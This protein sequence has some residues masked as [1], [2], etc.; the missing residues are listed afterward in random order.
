M[1]LKSKIALSIILSIAV[2]VFQST[3]AMAASQTLTVGV[4]GPF[5]GP[6]AKVG[7]EFRSSVEMA[8]EKIDYQIGDYKIEPVWIDSQSDPAKATSAYAEA[9]EKKGIQIG[10]LNW[11][12][13]VAAAVMDVAAQYKVPHIFGM[14]AAEIVNE[15]FAS[16]PEKYSYWAAKG[17]PVPGKLMLGYVECLNSAIDKG[18]FK[19]ANKKVAIRRGNGLGAQCG[20]RL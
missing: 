16:D 1:N 18:I 11:H 3:V 19:P 8:L 10:I 9:V 5:T 20:C 15:K 13:S 17:W 12:S 2:L 4:M 14:G 7:D 6:S